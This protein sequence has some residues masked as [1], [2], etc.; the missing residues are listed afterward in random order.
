MPVH[1]LRVVM[2]VG[3]AGLPST[4]SAAA[5]FKHGSEPAFVATHNCTCRYRG[6]DVQLGELRCL[7]TPEGPRSAQCVMEQN[8][9]SWHPV[10][11][12]CPEASLRRPVG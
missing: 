9:T 6:E 10:S 2:L 8:V 3:L 7:A 12:P 1:L 11:D 5:E 4:R